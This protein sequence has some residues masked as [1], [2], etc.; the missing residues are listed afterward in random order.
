MRKG[1]QASD[2]DRPEL[3]LS[4]LPHRPRRDGP[5]KECGVHGCLGN[6]VALC[7]VSWREGRGAFSQGSRRLTVGVEEIAVLILV[8]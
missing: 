7:I 1:V 6:E 8:K 2:H 3:C 5:R 4:K